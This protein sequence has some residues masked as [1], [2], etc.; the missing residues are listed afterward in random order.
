[1]TREEDVE[2]AE[3]GHSWVQLLELILKS[4]KDKEGQSIWLV[5]QKEPP[6]LS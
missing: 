5:K 4:P 3:V 2:V 1:M 6:A